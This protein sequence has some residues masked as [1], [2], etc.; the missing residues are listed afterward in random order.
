MAVLVLAQERV[1]ALLTLCITV[2]IVIQF[3]R[4]LARMA[5]KNHV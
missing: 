1:Q 4:L 3:V 2:Q 5:A